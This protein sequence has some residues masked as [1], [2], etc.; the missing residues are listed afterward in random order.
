MSLKSFMSVVSC[1]LLC[2]LLGACAPNYGKGPLS[3]SL[4]N[5]PGWRLFMS[6]SEERLN[7][8]GKV[9]VL[10]KVDQRWTVVN[11]LDYGK[12][13]HPNARAWITRFS[14]DISVLQG[15]G[16]SLPGFKPGQEALLVGTST[17]TITPFF[18]E[19]AIRANISANTRCYKDELVGK[20]GR[21]YSPS[22]Y[23][24]TTSSFI[25]PITLRGGGDFD[26][27]KI[28][29]AFQQA[30]ILQH[31]AALRAS[32]RDVYQQALDFASKQQINVSVINQTGFKLP[33]PGTLFRTEVKPLVQYK[34]NPGKFDEIPISYTVY[35][36]NPDN[37]YFIKVS[38]ERDWHISEG[39]VYKLRKIKE[40]AGSLG[41]DIVVT[42]LRAGDL[43]PAT[44]LVFEDANLR[45]LVKAIRFQ[46]GV[47]H[48]EADVENK[49]GKHLK[50]G[51]ISLYLGSGIST[52]IYKE[53]ILYPPSA[54]S[55]SF[56]EDF[57]ANFHEFRDGIGSFTEVSSPKAV[58][59]LGIAASYFVNGK[60]GSLYQAKVLTLA[61]V[62]SNLKSAKAKK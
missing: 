19:Y 17:K 4:N 61:K 16:Y 23:N 9:V 43:A 2:C 29:G 52:K 36:D 59:T 44:P 39:E 27:E 54:S 35:L 40:G 37:D 13:V 33:A 30:N 60:A 25:T 24:P 6:N 15:D 53:G 38:R 14:N 20:R 12:A 32:R 45:V 41:V 3:L 46:K 7:V 18:E 51:D 21:P 57:P 56:E 5:E 49:S 55:I 34:D 10:E 8:V 48:L 26:Q 62:M 50:L 1:F 58:A 42:G 31:I 11:I 22:S 47:A 28:L